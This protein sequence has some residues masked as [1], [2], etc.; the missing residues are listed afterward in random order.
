[1]SDIALPIHGASGLPLAERLL[2]DER[3]AKLAGRGDARA[4]TILYERHH[5]AIYRYCRSIVRN[6]H[7]AQ[8]AL[9]SA[10]ARAYTALCASER[11]LA[12]RPWLFRIAHNEAISILRR[13][14]REDQLVDVHES[15][16]SSVERTAQQRERLFI[17]LADLQELPER[18][19]AALLM[20][21]LS[22]LSIEEIAGA[23]SVSTGAAK[24]TLFEARSSL[25]EFVKGR[26]M[27]CEAV[28][29][30]I[31]EHDGRVLRGR[32]LR[33]HLRDCAGCRDF[34]ALI[35]RR[36]ADLRALAPPLPATLASATL[37]RL[38]AHGGSGGHAAGA[39][40]TAG[41]GLG[42][43]VAASLVA[44]GLTGVAVMA[45]ATAGTLHLTAG[46]GGSA[47]PNAISASG[48]N[49]ARSNDTETL[50][51]SG[52]STSSTS[53]V[54]STRGRS[55]A[56]SGSIS[57]SEAAPGQALVS[58]GARSGAG[59][60][61]GH[62]HSAKTVG[63][64]GTGSSVPHRTAS[65]GQRRAHGGSS[66][67]RSAPAR[68]H[69][70]KPAHPSSSPRPRGSHGGKPTEPSGANSKGAVQGAHAPQPH[71]APHEARAGGTSSGAGRA[72][73]APGQTLTPGPPA[74]Q[75]ER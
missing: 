34:Q 71:E 44:K 70:T 19:R 63:S 14:P 49:H 36:G 56:A 5:Q 20:R 32:G 9:Q 1:M 50:V 46:N 40:V 21:E 67:K 74:K 47:H 68:H 61:P 15:L 73:A 22:G 28:R 37:T 41:S 7:D 12:V 42:G 51:S 24:Q 27:E 33:A 53:T 55:S 35:E 11:D 69:A 8:D 43:H 45:A 25:H 4:F 3:L 6:D 13:R 66:P 23:L 2:S 16:D 48:R 18:Q 38:L 30:A 58:G 52:S 59:R 64:H 10:M 75:V 29:R 57:G 60:T 17:L 62:S 72:G 26:A 54:A 65:R 31:S 39:S